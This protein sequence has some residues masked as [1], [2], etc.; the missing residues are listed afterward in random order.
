MSI[1]I[2][3]K[4]IK[5][6]NE[7]N[8]RAQSKDLNY[9]LE[10][11]YK[12]NTYLNT[13]LKIKEQKTQSN[14]VFF[15]ESPKKF[16]INNN[17]R[18]NTKSNGLVSNANII[19]NQESNKYSNNNTNNNYR[20]IRRN[21]SQNFNKKKDLNDINEIISV[22]LEHEAEKIKINLL[23]YIINNQDINIILRNF[24]EV[25]EDLIDEYNINNNCLLDIESNKKIID[26]KYQIIKENIMQEY[27]IINNEIYSKYFLTNKRDDLNKLFPLTNFIKHCTQSNNIA[28]HK[29]KNP[30]YIIPNTN[31]IICK[32]TNEIYNKNNFECFCDFDG[33]IFISSYLVDN[34]NY[35]YKYK[36]NIFP[37]MNRNS[38]DDEKCLCMKC[39]HLLYYNSRNKKIKCF[40]CNTE[41]SD[42]FNKIFY[43]KIFFDKLRQEINFSLIMKRKSNPNKYCS[44][45]GLCFQGKFLEK[46][47][48]VCSKCQKCQYDIRNGRYKYKLYLFQKKKKNKE[49]DK[50]EIKSIKTYKNININTNIKLKI[51][52]ESNNIKINSEK[53]KRP[54]IPTV[55]VNFTNITKNNR[56]K[57][58]NYYNISCENL[59]EEKKDNKEYS[60]KEDSKD[61]LKTR[62]ELV[63]K[64]AKLLLL[65]NSMIENNKDIK[66]LFLAKN[67]NKTLVA[68]RKIRA[69]NGYYL[70]QK[71]NN[72]SKINKKKIDNKLLINSLDEVH[73]KVLEDKNEKNNIINN[74]GIIKKTLTNNYSYSNIN[75]NINTFFNLNKSNSS[76]KLFFPYKNHNIKR[77]PNIKKNNLPSDLNMAEYTIISII[78]SSSFSAVY[79]V[80][81]IFSKK[82]FAIKKII[83]SSKSNLEKWQKQHIE[84]LQILN[85]G[86]YLETIN[87][88]PT[89]QYCIK[90][91]DNM[92]YAIYELMPLAESDLNKKISNSRKNLNQEMLVKMLK[93]LINA[94]CYMQK[95]GIGHRDIKPENILIINKN[96]YIGDFDQS[97]HIKLNENN[98]SDIEEEI[99]GSEAFLSPIMLNA[100]MKNKKKVKHNIF[101]S[102]VYSFGLCFIYALTKNIFILQRIKEIKQ[103]EKINQFILDNL[104]EKKMEINQNFL[105]LIIKMVIWE[106]K[107]RPDFID[108]NDL[109]NER[110]L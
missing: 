71:E 58:N 9:R 81:N 105:D 1:S 52:S 15:K 77:I 73:N 74:R 103:T 96:Y 72:S 87:I 29:S 37:L 78:N 65:N 6:N 59:S 99:K 75:I 11:N 54:I 7:K 41:E 95:M 97:I 67:N 92:S 60:Y 109:I 53:N 50:K 2:R 90:K 106:E 64:K 13:K 102:D 36:N 56:N 10:K 33:E 91:L 17:L 12:A 45:G 49:N 18:N 40:K 43:N 107:F 42:D 55:I 82:Y 21:Y 93:Q 24:S 39:K 35:N 104:S 66:N 70:N 76:S 27:L 85:Q 88:M 8:L 48:L 14:P 32:E 16:H 110:K 51:S 28:L 34:S 79:K 47:I 69:L 19:L 61:I 3:K 83:F 44:C 94:F 80:Q 30:L 46:Y 68:S 4:Y 23:K 84:L 89:I 62:R 20:A 63:I 101:K 57:V 100:L 22:M 108:L 25:I 86:F 38:L 98:F 26:N 31:Y 5:Y